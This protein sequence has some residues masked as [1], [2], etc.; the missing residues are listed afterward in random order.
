LRKSTKPVVIFGVGDNAALAHHYFLRDNL[1]E[2]AAFTVDGSYISQP[3]FRGLPV[4]AFEDIQTTHPADQ[5][6]LFIAVG[7][8]RMNQN[9]QAKCDEAKAKGYRLA[10]YVSPQAILD[11]S[12]QPGDNCF[13]LEGALVQPFVRIGEGVTLWSGCHIGHDSQIDD[14]CFLAP[15]VSISGHVNVG[16]HCFLGI[17]STVRDHV[18]IAPRCLIGAAALI[19][20]DT[21]ENGVYTGHPARLSKR[22][23]DQVERI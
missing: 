16:H 10:S 23:S 17:N 22:P 5:F 15:R 18:T 1:R 4:R 7:Y 14:W 12:V 19:L 20:R 9:R 21:A 6:D 8:T 13:I 11:P 2:V 3:T